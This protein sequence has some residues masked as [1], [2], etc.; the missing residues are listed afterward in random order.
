MDIKKMYMYIC[1][2]IKIQALGNSE[3]IKGKEQKFCLLKNFCMTKD[4]IKSKEQ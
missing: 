4:N 1:K 2:C 3:A